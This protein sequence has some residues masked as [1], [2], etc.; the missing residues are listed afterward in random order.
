MEDKI[1]EKVSDPGLYGF[2]PKEFSLAKPLLRL[3]WR[4]VFHGGLEILAG[5]GII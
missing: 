3:Q 4:P 1:Q 2:L 5:T